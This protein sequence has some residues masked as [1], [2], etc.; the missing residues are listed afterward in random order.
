MNVLFRHFP[1]VTIIYMCVHNR[2]FTS[3]IITALLRRPY[4]V[5]ILML[6]FMMSHLCHYAV[7]PSRSSALRHV[8][9][10]YY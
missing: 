1:T 7:S 10:D 6:M 3:Y 9:V 5:D 2:S 4:P 8:A